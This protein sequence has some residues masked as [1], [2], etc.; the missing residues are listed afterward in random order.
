MRARV[1]LWASGC[2][3]TRLAQKPFRVLP[4]VFKVS[5]LSAWKKRISS[6]ELPRQP[7]LYVS[8]L[9]RT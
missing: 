7:L 3:L 5:Q 9:A 2:S 4:H 6:T 1:L 8:S